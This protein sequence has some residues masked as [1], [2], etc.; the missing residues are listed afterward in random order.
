DVIDFTDAVIVFSLAQSGSAEVEA[1]HGKSKAVQSF[2]RVE[3]DFVVQRSTEEWMGMANHGGVRRVLRVR[4]EQGFEA[5]SGTFEKKGADGL[6]RWD[7]VS[8]LHKKASY[9]RRRA[10]R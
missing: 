5:S 1:Q 4:I 2:H 3:D 6:V 8:R 9:L 7:H 10:S